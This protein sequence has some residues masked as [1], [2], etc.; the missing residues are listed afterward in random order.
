MDR[1]PAHSPASGDAA[2]LRVADARRAYNAVMSAWAHD[3]LLLRARGMLTPGLT[4]TPV[5][6]PLR[7]AFTLAGSR[8]SR[9]THAPSL[10]HAA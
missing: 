2:A 5:R 1:R 7:V 9:T 3:L 6:P 8:P 4:P 10:R